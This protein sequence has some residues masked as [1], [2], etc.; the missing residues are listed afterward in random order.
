[1]LKHFT[2]KEDESKKFK[3]IKVLLFLES[4][5]I[6]FFMTFYFFFVNWVASFLWELSF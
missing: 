5:L 1:M 2:N 3:V 4:H 6:V